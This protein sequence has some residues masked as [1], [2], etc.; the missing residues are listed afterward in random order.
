[1][2]SRLLERII[3]FLLILPQREQTNGRLGKRRPFRCTQR[4]EKPAPEMAWPTRLS[5]PGSDSSD[6]RFGT[7]VYR[8]RANALRAAANNIE[9]MSF[10]AGSAG[11][12]CLAFVGNASKITGLVLVGKS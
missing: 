7:R 12:E 8:P 5:I 4:E 9:K 2:S 10:L 6:P 3:L 11:A 1:M